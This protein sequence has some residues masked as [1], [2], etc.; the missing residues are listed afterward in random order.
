[1]AFNRFEEALVSYDMA[2]NLKPTYSDAYFNKGYCLFKLNRLDEAQASYDQ[3]RSVGH[4]I[5]HMI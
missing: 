4:F 2:T 5:G 3:W 1:M